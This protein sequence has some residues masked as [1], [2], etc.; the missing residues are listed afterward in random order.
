LLLLFRRGIDVA[1]KLRWTGTGDMW[2]VTCKHNKET[3]NNKIFKVS[4]TYTH[5]YTCT[6]AHT[7]TYTCI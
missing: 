7:Y 2:H 6:H 5:T 4:H 3:N 1:R